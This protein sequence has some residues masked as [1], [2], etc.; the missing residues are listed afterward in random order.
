[1]KSKR[2][3]SAMALML[4]IGGG[5]GFGAEKSP[6]SV[7]LDDL[8]GRIRSSMDQG[9]KTKAEL[10]ANLQEF[11]ELLKKYSGQQTDDVAEILVTEAR[12]YLQVLDDSAQARQLILRLKRDFPYTTQGRKASE[13][14]AAITRQEEAQRIRNFLVVGSKFPDFSEKDTLR[15][16][17]TLSGYQGRVVLLEFWATWS[18]SSV[19]EVSHL[20]A[21][22][23]QYR[24]RGFEII[25]ISLDEDQL[26]LSAFVTRN[27]MRW[28]QFC[29]GSTWNNKL[30]LKYGVNTLPANYLLDGEG[31]IIAKDLRGSELGEKVAAALEK[32]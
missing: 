28:P 32:K 24:S 3:I 16:Q 15:N 4:L 21:V 11:D 30:A 19:A 25:G 8:V 26:K 18:K 1:M 5:Y 29:D 20:L 12:L 31:K 27:K 2:W 14:L 6:V 7:E 22:Y 13:L 23:N 10:A 9:R 17:L